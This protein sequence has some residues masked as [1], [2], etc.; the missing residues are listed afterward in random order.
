MK[1]RYKFPSK[2]VIIIG[3]IVTLSIILSSVSAIIALTIEHSE[4]PELN[5]ILF[6]VILTTVTVLMVDAN[7]K[8][9]KLYRI[10]ME[11]DTFIRDIQVM[12]DPEQLEEYVMWQSCHYTT[13]KKYKLTNNN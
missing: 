13:I 2:L 1:N 11:Y 5:N 3:V 9:I 4:H 8:I 6:L 10:S 7:S 12:Y